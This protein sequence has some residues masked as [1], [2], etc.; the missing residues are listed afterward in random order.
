[1]KEV[2]ECVV[3]GFHYMREIL[4]FFIELVSVKRRLL[5]TD[6]CTIHKQRLDYA[7]ILITTSIF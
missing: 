4:F 1:M 2:C 3:I 6:E 5:K 7:R